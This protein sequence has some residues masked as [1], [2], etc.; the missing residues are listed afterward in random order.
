LKISFEVFCFKQGK[1]IHAFFNSFLSDEAGQAGGFLSV[2]DE[3]G[4][5][6]QKFLKSGF[7]DFLKKVMLKR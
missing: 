7:F 5:V 6:K 4:S 2:E 3:K 1:R